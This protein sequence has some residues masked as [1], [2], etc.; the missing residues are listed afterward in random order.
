MVKENNMIIRFCE[1]GISLG[2]RD[3]GNKLREKIEES[4]ENNDKVIFDLD[5]I[6]ILSNSFADECFAKLLLK[7]DFDTIKKNTSFINGNNSNNTIILKAF[8][9]RMKKINKES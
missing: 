5:N 6:E 8:K 4:I 2:T 3:L 7:F 9:D 1:L